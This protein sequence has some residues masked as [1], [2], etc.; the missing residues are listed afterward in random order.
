VAAAAQW[1]LNRRAL[2]SPAMASA[3]PLLAGG[4][5]I[6]A[7]VYQWLPLKGACLSH[8]RSA[9]HFF[10]P[11][12]REGALGALIMGARHGTYCVGCCWLLM[13]LLFVAGVMNLLWVIT[14]A[15][16]VLV[17]KL[18]P[19][20]VRLG[21]AAGAMLVVWGAWILTRG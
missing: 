17:E 4:L 1:E 7:G 15:A 11:E 2:L 8:C 18:V 10:G 3:S 13:T 6:A 21:R 16:L 9:L 5:L 12:W 19:G 20:G 14:L